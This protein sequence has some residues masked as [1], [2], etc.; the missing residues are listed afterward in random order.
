MSLIEAN[1][2][3]GGAVYGVAQMSYTVDGA[4]GKDYGAALAAASLKQAA[5]IEA[6]AT[7]YSSVVKARAR[8]V[9]DL[10]ALMAQLSYAIASL[11]VKDTSSSDTASLQD[12]T[13]GIA[14]ANAYGI[15]GISATMTRSA[16]YKA[17][18]DVQYAMDTEDN[19]LQQDVLALQG[20][21]S[22]RDNAF[23]TASRIVRKA[24]DAAGN[25]IKN[26]V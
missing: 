14:I 25:T 1:V 21:L 22:K 23:S 16:L 13:L 4:A 11:K 12:S 3:Q 9:E 26:I 20:L 7:A 6:S 15:P 2:I 24:D 17:Q 19:N 10:G 5:S 18:N 8:K